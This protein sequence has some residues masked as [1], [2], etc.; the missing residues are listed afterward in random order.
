MQSTPNFEQAFLLV[1]G[2]VQGRAALVL[3]RS[4]DNPLDHLAVIQG[5]LVKL[6]LPAGI[7]IVDL[8][9]STATRT[10]R[11]YEMLFDGFECSAH[12]VKPVQMGL[13]Q[14]AT[15]TA[16]YY[17]QEPALFDM[18]RLSPEL[19]YLVKTG[20]PLPAYD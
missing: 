2:P 5:E 20:V 12:S 11:F 6:G 10:R 13:E 17:A 18:A 9:M 19:R 1:P 7:V 15:T 14:L 16:A 3:A 4:V 8:L